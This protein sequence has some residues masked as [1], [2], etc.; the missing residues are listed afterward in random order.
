MLSGSA[1]AKAPGMLEDYPWDEIAEQTVFDLGGGSGG[2]LALLLRKHSCMKGGILELA[3]SIE[4]AQTNFFDPERCY[5]DVAAQVP[6]ENLIIGDYT[7]GVPS[8][9]VYTMKWCLHD[10]DDDDAITS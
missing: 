2:M 6:K 4:L 10:W 1:I 5:A 8:C 9:E 3:K 7:K